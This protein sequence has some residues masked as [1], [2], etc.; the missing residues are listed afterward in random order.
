MDQTN[1]PRNSQQAAFAAP[2]VCRA[3][4]A[5]PSDPVELQGELQHARD[6]LEEW[7]SQ[8]IKMGHR[9]HKL[10]YEV[11]RQ[12]MFIDLRDRKFSDEI[13][14][15]R[16]TIAQHEE[17]ISNLKRSLQY[18]Q[19]VQEESIREKEHMA[20][21]LKAERQK[22]S[23]KTNELLVLNL[24]KQKIV[25]QQNDLQNMVKQLEQQ[26]R[27][28]DNENLTLRKHNDSLFHSL[29][30]TNKILKANKAEFQESN[31]AWQDKYKALQEKFSDKEQVWDTKQHLEEQKKELGTGYWPNGCVRE[32]AAEMT[33]TF[34]SK[35]VASSS[36]DAFDS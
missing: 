14:K 15:S 22:A 17:E 33:G 11:N 31:R 5:L 30:E 34:C 18:M 32:L 12:D 24:E 1:D 26:L 19:S 27:Q 16:D 36:V 9:I 3:R 8:R 4:A 7:G 20:A 10:K 13:Q 29:T 35:R 6:V 28:R 2:Q 23:E 25:L 21:K